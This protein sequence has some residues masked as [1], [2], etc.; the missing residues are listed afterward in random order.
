[1]RRTTCIWSS[2]SSSSVLPSLGQHVTRAAQHALAEGLGV[3]RPD[4][5]VRGGG[6]RWDPAVPV[7]HPP[8]RRE[9][10]RLPAR[11]GLSVRRW[12]GRRG[13]RQRRAGG[14]ING[15]GWRLRANS[16]GARC[17]FGRRS[18]SGRSVGRGPVGQVGRRLVA[19]GL[20]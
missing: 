2:A 20:A 15:G 17:Q 18:V 1:M 19:R 11:R 6:H 9:L 12:A 14:A 3:Q 5:A 13:A 4:L 7:E 8:P 10:V 16:V